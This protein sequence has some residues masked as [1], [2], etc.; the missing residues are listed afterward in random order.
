MQLHIAFAKRYQ[1]IVFNQKSAVGRAE[2]A[3]VGFSINDLNLGMFLTHHRVANV[4]ATLAANHISPAFHVFV[5][6]VV[7]NPATIR[8]AFSRRASAHRR[9]ISLSEPW[10]NFPYIFNK[11]MVMNIASIRVKVIPFFELPLAF[12]KVRKPSIALETSM[13]AGNVQIGRT[14]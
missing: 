13:D 6:L 12:I 1:P 7:I 2:I 10:S 3:Q 4:Y 5:V 11:G 14:R 9:E 8:V